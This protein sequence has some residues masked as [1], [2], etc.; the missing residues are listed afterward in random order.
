MQ[1]HT[2][3]YSTVTVQV[4]AVLL[5]TIE[6][7]DFC[8]TTKE[9]L[10]DRSPNDWSNADD[11]WLVCK[12]ATTLDLST[13]NGTSY[14]RADRGP[15]VFLLR[16]LLRAEGGA[17]RSCFPPLSAMLHERAG[18]FTFRFKL[19]TQS[20]VRMIFSVSANHKCQISIAN[21]HIYCPF[22]WHA[23]GELK[24]PTK[25]NKSLT[26][27]K[28]RRIAFIRIWLSTFDRISRGGI[29]TYS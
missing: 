23:P 9:R 2:I 22:M 28:N 25:H 1:Q 13:I 17:V 16:A 15:S 29:R 7:E 11:D 18:Q 5:R 20:I 19:A 3:Q 24:G 8:S 14:L 26:E 4:L 6:L 21:V 12:A 10:N 27:S